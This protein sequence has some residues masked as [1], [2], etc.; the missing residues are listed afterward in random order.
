MDDI[1]FSTPSVLKTQQIFDISQQCLKASGLIIAPI[2]IQTSTPYYY[3][4]FFFNIQHITPHLTQIHTDKLST[5]ND[6][7]EILGI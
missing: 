4:R 1:L 5:L 7:Q 3:I 2:K 6:F